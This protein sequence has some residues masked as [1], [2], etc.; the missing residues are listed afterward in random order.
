MLQKSILAIALL[1]MSVCIINAQVPQLIN[2]QGVLSDATGNKING[3]RSIQFSIYNS[4]TGGTAIWTETQTVVVTDGLFSVLLGS[5]TLIPYAVFNGSDKYLSLKVGTDP[6]MIPRK[7]LVSVGYSFRAYDADKVDGKDAAAFVQ[8]MDGVSPAS[9]GN[10]DLIAGA[11]VTITPDIPNHK[12]TISGGGGGDN[13]GNHT[14]T[15]NI[16][17][18]GNWLS[19]DGGNEGVFVDNSGN[20][21]IGTKTPGTKLEIQSTSQG[22]WEKGVRLLNPNMQVNNK[23]LY[24][25]GRTDNNKNAG[26]LYFHYAGD[27]SVNNRISLEIGR[28]HV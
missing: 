21:G 15:Q 13:L 12:I 10:I 27:A 25:V 22:P 17:L 5:V 9:D 23:L 2:Y 28:A 4:A 20:I 19:G 1:L 6:E 8:K 7:R 26:Q 18:N 3:S 16:K 14:A 24:I 11:N